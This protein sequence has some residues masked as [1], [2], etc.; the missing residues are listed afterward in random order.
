MPSP[1]QQRHQ[2]ANQQ[3]QAEAALTNGAKVLVLD[4]ATARPPRS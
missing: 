3:Q 1:L 4:P 2:D